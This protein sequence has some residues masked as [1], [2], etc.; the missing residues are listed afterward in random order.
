MAKML[1]IK[2]RIKARKVAQHIAI[3]CKNLEDLQAAKSAENLASIK[4][5]CRRGE[6]SKK[7][8][9]S[10]S[11]TQRGSKRPS[12]TQTAAVA[13]AALGRTSELE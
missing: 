11:G 8:T 2:H 3:A 6:A 1:E 4:E 12:A 9:K 5:S 10:T 13:E 7:A